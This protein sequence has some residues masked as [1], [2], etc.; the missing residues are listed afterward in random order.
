M[1]EELDGRHFRIAR[2]APKPAGLGAIPVRAAVRV[3]VGNC[4]KRHKSRAAKGS[5]KH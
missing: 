4:Q 5:V 2:T 3:T 1:G